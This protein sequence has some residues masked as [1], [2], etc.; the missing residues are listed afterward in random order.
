MTTNSPDSRPT[1]VECMTITEVPGQKAVVVLNEAVFGPLRATPKQFTSMLR[2]FCVMARNQLSEDIRRVSDTTLV[3]VS[4]DKRMRT[5]V[6]ELK[7]ALS[8]DGDF[9]LLTLFGGKTDPS[10]PLKDALTHAIKVV[11]VAEE[12]YS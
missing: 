1:A 10:T 8:D 6:M 11:S 3:P 12:Q 2:S 9:V 4:Q 7:M 5:L